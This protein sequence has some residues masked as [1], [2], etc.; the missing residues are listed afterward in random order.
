MQ[1]GGSLEMFMTDD[2]KKYYMAMKRMSSKSPQKS[3][4]RP[5]VSVIHRQEWRR[6]ITWFKL[7][8]FWHAQ[9]TLKHGMKINWNTVVLL[10]KKNI[11]YIKWRQENVYINLVYPLVCRI[12]P[13]WKL[14]R[15]KNISSK[16]SKILFA[17]VLNI[18]SFFIKP[19]D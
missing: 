6:L 15:K 14:R 5:S 9:S 11:Q 10:K 1:A 7:H 2:Q 12:I 17:T 16:N 3:I 8:T 4:P 18:C 19:Y 13:C